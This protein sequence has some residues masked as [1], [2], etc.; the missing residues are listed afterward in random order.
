MNDVS[1]NLQQ[2]PNVGFV[3]FSGFERIAEGALAEVA[4]AAWRVSQVDPTAVTL[5][6]SRET[7]AVFDLNL[8]GE[9]SDIAQRYQNQAAAPLKRG[10][11]KLGVVA[12]EITLLPSHW[13][14]LA[15]QPGGASVALRRLVETARK[16]TASQK[17]TR[18]AAT[19]KFMAA[20]AG[21]LQGFEEASRSLFAQ[22]LDKLENQISGWPPDIVAELKGMLN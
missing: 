7:G 17:N 6:F 18:I 9:A 12:R 3:C 4:L 1:D 21:D 10:R 15:K 20:I 14:W 13:E 2:P 19:Y 5:T 16:E 11:P 22:Q 8:R